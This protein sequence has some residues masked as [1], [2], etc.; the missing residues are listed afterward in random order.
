MRL[1]FSLCLAATT[2]T[3]ANADAL[4]VRSPSHD[5]FERVCE[6]LKDINQGL[7]SATIATEEV[8]E[9]LLDEV[10]QGHNS[11]DMNEAIKKIGSIIV[12][13][14]IYSTDPDLINVVYR[15]R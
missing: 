3:A 14:E 8:R 4:R 13:L 11:A 6:R 2:A 1:I 15:C 10:D 12:G 5:D 9:I 7:I